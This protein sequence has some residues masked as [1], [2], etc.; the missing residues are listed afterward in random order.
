MSSDERERQG[1]RWSGSA[2]GTEERY[3]D[4]AYD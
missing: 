3:D 4:Q 1:G 2:G